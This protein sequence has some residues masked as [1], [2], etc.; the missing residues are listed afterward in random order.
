MRRMQD[1]FYI[2]AFPDNN[3]VVYYGIQLYEFIKYVPTE[4]NQL[5]LLRAEY[6]SA[7]CRSKTKFEMVDKDEMEDFLNDDIYGYGDFCWVDFNKRENVEGLEPLEIAELLYLGH[8]FRPVKS[9][10]FDKIQNRYAYLAH[11]DGWFCRLYCRYYPDFEDVIA[12]KVIDMVSTSKRRKI[13]PFPKELKGE[14]MNL[15]K[16]GLLIDFS[17]T[18]KSSK[19]IEIPIYCIGKFLNMD[20]MYN[21][22]KRHIKRSKYSARLFHENKKWF[23]DY[24]IVS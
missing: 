8:M 2:N 22:L 18:L 10:F 14:L 15:A 19:S 11:D 16:D 7:G 17:N 13:Y 6:Y 24:I 3:E 12:N 4:L 9:P 1:V 20:D 21:D 5:L 23:I